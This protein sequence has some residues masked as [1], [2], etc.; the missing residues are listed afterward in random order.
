MITCKIG[1]LVTIVFEI[2]KKNNKNPVQELFNYTIKYLDPSCDLPPEAENKLATLVFLYIRTNRPVFTTDIANSLCNNKRGSSKGISNQTIDYTFRDLKKKNNWEKIVQKS[3]NGKGRYITH[4]EW[5]SDDGSHS[6][7]QTEDFWIAGK[8][9]YE[10]IKIRAHESFLSAPENSI[11]PLANFGSLPINVSVDEKTDRPLLKVI[12]NN[13]DHLYIVG[14]GGIGKTTS[15]LCIMREAYDGKGKFDNQPIPLFVELSKAYNADDF[16][17]RGSSF[18]IRNTIQRQLQD[19]FD[20]REITRGDVERVFK[21]KTN[22]PEFALLLDGLNEVSRDIINGHEILSMVAAEIRHIMSKYK[23]V[24]VILTSRSVEELISNATILYLS[25][26][27]P[28]TIIDYLQD[29]FSEEKIEKIQRN[30]QLLGLLRIPLFLIIYSKIEEDNN[31]LSRGEILNTYYSQTRH[32]LYSEITRAKTIK[33]ELIDNYGIDDNNSNTIPSILIFLLDFIIPEIAW[34]MVEANKNHISLQEIKDAV[35]YTLSDAPDNMYCG[36]YGKQCFCDYPKYPRENTL[37]VAKAIRRIFGEGYANDFDI[38]TSNVCDCLTMRL[39][40]FI[41]DND[42]EYN[43][44]H[45]HIRDYFAALYHINHLRLALY[46]N[47]KNSNLLARSC[48]SAWIS[49]PLPIQ[50]LIFI[51]EILGETHNSLQAD[52]KPEDKPQKT[53]ISEGLNIFRDREPENRFKENDGYAVWNL[54]QILKMVRND[55]SGEDFSYLDLS[56]CELNGHRLGR[57]RIV[58]DFTGAKVDDKSFMP[59][60]HGSVVNTAFFSPKNNYIITA[61]GDR[62]AKIWDSKTYREIGTLKG[63]ANVLYSACFNPDE[64]KIITASRDCTCKIWSADLFEE[65]K[66]L[67]YNSVVYSAIFNSDGTE[68]AIGLKDGTIHL[69]DAEFRTERIAKLNSKPVKS[70]YSGINIVRYSNKDKYIIA[71]SNDYTAKIIDVEKCEEIPESPLRHDS[72]VLYAE[73]SKDS[74]QIVTAC[75]DGSVNIWD[76]K[77]DFKKLS[78]TKPENSMMHDKA[79]FYAVFNPSGDHIASVS[80]D[81]TIKI[82]DSKKI[83]EIKTIKYIDTSVNSIQYDSDGRRFIVSFSDHTFKIFDA[84]TYEDLTSGIEMGSVNSIFSAQFSPDAKSVVTALANNKIE[85]WTKDVNGKFVLMNRF[86]G[87]RSSAYSAQFSPKDGKYIVSSSSDGSIIIRTIKS[88]SQSVETRIIRH[89]HKATINCVQW[90]PH[91]EKQIVSASTDG[92]CKIWNTENQEPIGEPLMH[93]NPV[94]T[95]CFSKDGKYI[96]T[97]SGYIASVWKIEADNTYKRITKNN[98]RHQK[99]VTSATF[100]NDGQRILTASCD[101]TVKE[102]IRNENDEYELGN[103]YEMSDAINDAQYFGDYVIAASVDGTIMIWH[104]SNP[105]KGKTLEPKQIGGVRSVRFS[106][107]GNFIVSSSDDGI[108]MVWLVEHTK[109]DN[110]IDCLDIKLIDVIGNI[111]GIFIKGVDLSNLW[112]GYYLSDAVREY[113]KENGALFDQ[114]TASSNEFNEK[115]QVSKSKVL[116]R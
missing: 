27:S 94:V 74:S 77:D 53:L 75:K 100:S 73:F 106:D 68:I 52:L 16:D 28:Q 98:M 76:V 17:S 34:K 44:I 24:R 51:G 64:S 6:V 67:A 56:A 7:V 20:D 12:H 116:E 87:H 46:I 99:I 40:I 1:N 54:L 109:P 23:N 83:K 111:P 9:S 69:W 113:L 78:N 82:W 115:Y 45:Q 2:T 37:K 95:A 36:E 13:F 18:Y 110:D 42:N 21:E 31:L 62:T 49:N 79:V 104:S 25:G 48:L 108:A 114:H 102:W 89:A 15:L 71:S 41:K 59:K 22:Q 8:R 96:V 60:G 92:S 112:Q 90:N 107:D 105:S 91:N 81:C 85:L 29:K 47:K 35:C 10:E 97:A 58:A 88:N 19:C 57:G 26:I 72:E 11:L 61:S 43:V 3:S 50:I 80:E 65:E 38:I 14:E 86:D 30:K 5:S 63:H 84:I 93:G 33:R 32:V 70:R 66:N 4:L 39:G 103:K 101:K 55:L